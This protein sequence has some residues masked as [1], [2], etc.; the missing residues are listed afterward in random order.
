M[1]HESHEIKTAVSTARLD[2][3]II[4]ETHRKNPAP[5][6]TVLVLPGGG[7]GSLSARETEPI[8]LAFN[9]MGVNAC[10]LYYSCAPAVFP[11]ALEEAARA[12]AYMRNHARAWNVGKIFVNGYSAGGHLA[13]SLGV[14]WN[15]DFLHER[16]G[17]SARQVRPDGLILAY[18]VITSG[19]FR[20]DG[21]FRNLLGADYEDPQKRVLVSLEEQVSADTPPVFIWSTYEDTAVPV[22]N[23]LLFAC[24]L[25]QKMVPLEMHIYPPGPHGL[26]RGD[27]E[28]NPPEQVYPEVT[29]WMAQSVRWLNG[30]K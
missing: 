15:R 11:T 24:S 25:R 18:P 3:Y 29:Q 9:A 12:V 28:M 22:E 6:P 20:H 4:S 1:I 21:S 27:E 14:F 19:A 17:L 2:T 5:R 23:T 7:Y 10:V 16:T 13:A 30:L 8:A 26:S